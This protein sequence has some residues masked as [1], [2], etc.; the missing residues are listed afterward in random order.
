MI[1]PVTCVR[2][3]AA[4]F[5][6]HLCG[7]SGAGPLNARKRVGKIF[8]RQRLETAHAAPPPETRTTCVISALLALPVA[9]RGYYVLSVVPRPND[10]RRH[11]PLPA[12]TI[13]CARAEL[14]RCDPQSYSGARPRHRRVNASRRQCRLAARS[15][16]SSRPG[17]LHG[18]FQLR[19]K[20]V[21][22]GTSPTSGARHP[23]APRT[24]GRSSWQRTRSSP[25]ASRVCL[26]SSVDPCSGA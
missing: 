10:S 18:V 22:H 24:G 14:S 17:A 26:W 11:P 12:L 3:L 1:F 7:I 13:A 20:H 15:P 4:G 9:A 19:A 25:T 2:L 23:R 8:K 6:S 5:W 16:H 21:T